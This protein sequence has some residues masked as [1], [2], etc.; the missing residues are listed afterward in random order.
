M[1]YTKS[2]LRRNSIIQ[3]HWD[4]K[5][6]DIDF[7][8]YRYMVLKDQNISSIPKIYSNDFEHMKSRI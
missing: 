8:A 7:E 1:I 4:D 5:N 6:P 2:G 3:I